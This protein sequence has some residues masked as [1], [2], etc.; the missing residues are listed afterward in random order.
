M[1]VGRLKVPCAGGAKRRLAASPPRRRW[2]AGQQAGIGQAA[3]CSPRPRQGAGAVACLVEQALCTLRRVV[4]AYAQA[5]LLVHS[6]LV[7]NEIARAAGAHPATAA[8]HPGSA[9]RWRVCCQRA[10]PRPAPGGNA[11]TRPRS[12][13][14]TSPR[15]SRGSNAPC[16]PRVCTIR[17][18]VRV[19]GVDRPGGNGP[20]ARKRAQVVAQANVGP[21]RAVVAPGCSRRHGAQTRHRRWRCRAPSR[22][23][24]GGGTGCP[25]SLLPMLP[26]GRAWRKTRCPAVQSGKSHGWW[27]Q[28]FSSRPFWARKRTNSAPPG[29]GALWPGR[30]TAAGRC[31][32]RHCSSR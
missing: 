5:R 17:L 23:R 22:V 24:T 10:R 28:R 30:L 9:S 16:R 18:A 1:P 15:P 11:G 4:A 19:P 26:C 12:Q 21:A 8:W 20:L 3:R 6:G 25:A 14:T 29:W 2:C 27:A 32:W 7:G 13:C 31:H